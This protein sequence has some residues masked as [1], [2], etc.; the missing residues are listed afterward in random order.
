MISRALFQQLSTFAV[1]GFSAMG[2]HWL[3]AVF[4]EGFVFES[5]H[6]SAPYLANFLAFLVAFVVSYLGH[7][8]LTFQSNEK[9]SKTLT[10]FFLT[11]LLG[12][13]VNEMLLVLLLNYTP[14]SFSLALF[15]VL[16]VVA[17]LTFIIS[18]FWAFNDSGSSPD[19]D[20]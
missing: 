13:V 17:V 1:V 11:A 14:L 9:H 3:V 6:K 10:R 5:S 12:F 16:N 4:L 7:R 20:V 15:I 19:T 18:K 2:V 8:K